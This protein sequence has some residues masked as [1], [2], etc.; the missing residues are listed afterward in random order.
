MLQLVFLLL[1]RL[2]WLKLLLMFLLLLL[3]LLLW[4]L[5]RL[6][7]LLF[8]GRGMLFFL[9]RCENCDAGHLNLGIWQD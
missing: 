8:S 7:L 5:L 9:Y 2:L 6:L 3:L 4:G 1:H